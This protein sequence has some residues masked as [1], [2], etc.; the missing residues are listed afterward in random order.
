MKTHKE[1]NKFEPCRPN[2]RPQNP[3]IKAPIKGSIIIVRYIY[4]TI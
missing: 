2:Q 3:D 1:E 4:N